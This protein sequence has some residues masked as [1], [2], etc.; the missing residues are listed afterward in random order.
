MGEN[1]KPRRRF[2]LTLQAGA[3]DWKEL[4]GAARE[5][6]EYLDERIAASPEQQEI[7]SV[8]GGVGIGWSVKL[9]EDPEM[10]HDRYF[11]MIEEYRKRNCLQQLAEKLD[12]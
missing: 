9:E 3:D 11:E 2:H 7:N 4:R 6:V 8:T 1:I 5:I 12:D 10:T